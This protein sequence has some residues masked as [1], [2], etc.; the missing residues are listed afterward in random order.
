M[1]YTSLYD[2]NSIVSQMLFTMAHA[3]TLMA[4]VLEEMSAVT[5]SI[6]G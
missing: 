3:A 6:P 5:I 4:Y 1:I 2:K